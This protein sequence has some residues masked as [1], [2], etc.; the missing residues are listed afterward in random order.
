M[1][2]RYPNPYAAVR[3]FTMG[4]LVHQIPIPAQIAWV[5]SQAVPYEQMEYW[6]PFGVHRNAV[7]LRPWAMGAVNYI[8]MK[9]LT[10]QDLAHAFREPDQIYE[11]IGDYVEDLEP[12]DPTL[13]AVARGA[14]D[15]MNIEACRAN[16]LE[17]WAD[18]LETL[19]GQAALAAQ[20][21]T[22]IFDSRR[23]KRLLRLP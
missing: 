8:S 13:I 7:Y 14:Q 6:L 9:T 19:Y 22:L 21:G 18:K 16:G 17:E 15:A 10:A 5:E 2:T 3:A 23:I 11:G 1:R 12:N 20:S 4:R